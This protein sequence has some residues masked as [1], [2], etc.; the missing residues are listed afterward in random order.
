[1]QH[2]R[3]LNYSEDLGQRIDKIKLNTTGLKRLCNWKNVV[4]LNY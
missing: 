4:L 3:L 1:M 2:L